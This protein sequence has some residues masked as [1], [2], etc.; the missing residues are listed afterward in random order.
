MIPELVDIGSPWPVLPPG[1]HDATLE[2]I[3][4]RFAQT[5][6]RKRLFDGLRQG[7]EALRHAG[8]KTVYVDGSFVTGK[9]EPGDYDAC[10]DTTGVEETK[11]DR[12]FLD[13]SNKRERQKRKLLGEFFPSGARADGHRTFV[14][15]FQNDRYTDEPKG[16]IRV[17]LT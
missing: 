16:I 9:P 1:E 8:C 12:V 5:P 14:E 4:E 2:E 3:E 17:Q 15:Y 11:L 7:V 6:H 13:F 10:W